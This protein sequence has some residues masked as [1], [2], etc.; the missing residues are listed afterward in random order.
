MDK[1]APFSVAVMPVI[2]EPLMLS[3]NKKS[4]PPPATV[5]T[6]LF[7]EFSTTSKLTVVAAACVSVTVPNCVAVPQSPERWHDVRL[8]ISA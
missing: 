8:K 2:V 5:S 4:E 1:G 7:P 3:L 6:N